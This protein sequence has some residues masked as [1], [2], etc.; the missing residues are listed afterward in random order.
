MEDELKKHRDNLQTLVEEQVQKIQ[1]INT[2]KAAIFDSIRD[3]FYVLSK[4][5]R[6][7]YINKAA[8]QMADIKLNETHIGKN[9]WELFPESVGDEMY[10]I[11]HEAVATN[12]PRHTI[13]ENIISKID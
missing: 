8:A 5:W 9:M 6:L 3:P 11:Y 1:E 4:E 13:I 7:T 2:E 12:A 10:Q